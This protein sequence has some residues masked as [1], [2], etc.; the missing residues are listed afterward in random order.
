MKTSNIDND[1][2]QKDTDENKEDGKYKK[3]TIGRTLMITEEQ[4]KHKQQRNNDGHQ[5]PAAVFYLFISSTIRQ[6]R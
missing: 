1:N 6:L 5:L 4:K 2:E 3:L